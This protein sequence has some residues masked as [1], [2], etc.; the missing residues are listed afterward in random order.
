M[1]ALKVGDVVT[2]RPAPGRVVAD[3]KTGRRL[4]AET[5]IRIDQFWLRRITD[6]D[7]EV[8]S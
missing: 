2:I 5:L 1:K 6:G 7:V 4:S 8:V 3:P